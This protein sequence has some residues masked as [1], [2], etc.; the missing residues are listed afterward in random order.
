MNVKSLH[1]AIGLRLKIMHSLKKSCAKQVKWDFLVQQFLRPMVDWIW[2]LYRPCLF[3]NIFQVVQVLL[4]LHLVHT[5]ELEQCQS[6]FTELRNKNKN[7]CQNQ[8][9]VNGLEPTALLNQERVAMPIQ[10]KL[11]QPYLKMENTTV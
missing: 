8:P 6:P 2:V 5:Q 3:V 1:I 9:R 11:Q 4:V 10:E 7:M